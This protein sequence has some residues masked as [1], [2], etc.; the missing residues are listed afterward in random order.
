MLPQNGF[1]SHSERQA[2][3]DFYFSDLKI[4][5]IALEIV[6]FTIADGF[7]MPYFQLIHLYALYCGEGA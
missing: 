4:V 7:D 1:F 6:K 3:T 2:F 5:L